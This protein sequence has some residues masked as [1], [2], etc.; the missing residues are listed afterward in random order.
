M[1]ISAAARAQ[2]DRVRLSR[3]LDN[4][5]RDAKTLRNTARAIGRDEDARKL[6]G[7]IR[8]LDSAQATLSDPALLHPTLF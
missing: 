8:C 6:N 3:M 1:E 4:L 5:T 7:V 2:R